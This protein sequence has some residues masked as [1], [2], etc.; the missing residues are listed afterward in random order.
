MRSE[1]KCLIP[2]T[3]FFL[4]LVGP[5]EAAHANPWMAIRS[6]GGDSTIYYALSQIQRIVFAADSLKVMA[7]DRVDAYNVAQV[8]KVEFLWRDPVGVENPGDAT[9]AMKVMRLLGNRPNPFSLE[10]RIAFEL[11]RAG[12]V[13]LKIYGVDGRLVRTLVKGDQPAGR[14]EEVWDGRDNSGRKLAGG[15]YFYRLV[16]LGAAG[17][18]RLIVLP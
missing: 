13:E 16:T 15:M 10:T 4:G 7:A 3:P 5:P 14:R 17:S 11:P 12:P 2:L 8:A 6:V 18:R 9:G 1:L